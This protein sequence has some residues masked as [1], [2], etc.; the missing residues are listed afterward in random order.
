M[1][2][3]AWVEKLQTCGGALTLDEVELVDTDIE[4]LG[5]ALQANVRSALLKTP[6]LRHCPLNSV[7]VLVWTGDMIVRL[8]MRCARVSCMLRLAV[9]GFACSTNAG[10]GRIG[11]RSSVGRGWGDRLDSRHF[12]S[13]CVA[14][15]ALHCVRIFNGAIFEMSRIEVY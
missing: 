10:V 12:L 4:Q 2:H 5:A 8:C 14:G 1:A 6:R 7:P 13:H 3:N 15:A 9:S 11:N